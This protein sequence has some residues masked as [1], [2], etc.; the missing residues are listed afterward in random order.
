MSDTRV[1]SAWSAY[2]EAEE[3]RIRRVSLARLGDL[4]EALH[5]AEEGER[6]TWVRSLARRYE[7]GQ[8]DVPVRMPLFGEIIFPAL[9]SDLRS[10][11]PDAA[12]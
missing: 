8:L 10:D 4:I 5:A 12:R 6:H 3:V 1:A 2:V 9:L 11:A 7:D